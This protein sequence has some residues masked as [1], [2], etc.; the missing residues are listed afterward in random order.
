MTMIQKIKVKSISQNNR[1]KVDKHNWKTIGDVDVGKN[2][3]KDELKL[4]RLYNETFKANK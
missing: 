1:K 4:F 3:G 2:Y